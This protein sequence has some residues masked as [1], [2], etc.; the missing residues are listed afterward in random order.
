MSVG[1]DQKRPRWHRI[2]HHRSCKRGHNA[3]RERSP[4]QESLGLTTVC[5]PKTATHAPGAGTAD[6]LPL[7]AIE[8]VA[9]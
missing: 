7:D 1:V 5:E 9:A 2:W 4:T 8:L 6:D 3:A